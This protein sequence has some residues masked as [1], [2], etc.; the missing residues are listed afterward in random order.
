MLGELPKKAKEKLKVLDNE[1][2][3][4]KCW[5]HVAE[6]LFNKSGERLSIIEKL[7]GIKYGKTSPGKAFLD[8]LQTTNP[9]MSAKEIKEICTKERRNDIVLFL[10][11]FEEVELLSRIDDV[12]LNELATKLD[13]G[14]FWEHLADEFDFDHKTKDQIG[15]GEKSV[16]NTSCTIG[17]LQVLKEKKPEMT[18][19]DLVDVCN[20]L[21]IM[22]VVKDLK[23]YQ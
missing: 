3:H 18:V 10:E 20:K 14:E 2:P 5:R 12:K 1:S 13:K 4:L 21:E 11:Q 23:E 22:N 19:S 7:N 16:Q 17:L 15:K 8:T 6:E 9:E